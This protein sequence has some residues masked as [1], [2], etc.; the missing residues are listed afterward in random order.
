MA[1]ILTSSL[2][3]TKRDIEDF[4][5]TPAFLGED[6][7]RLMRV[8]TDVKG[9]FA[10]QKLTQPTNITKANSTGFTGQGSITQTEK[11]LTVVPLKAEF[12]QNGEAF[13]QTIESM[14]LAQGYNLDDV[15]QMGDNFWREIILPVIAKAI[16]V[17]KNRMIWFGDT[18]AEVLSGT[19]PNSNPTGVANTNLTPYDGL[20]TKII[21]D[22]DSGDIASDQKKAYASS[23]AGV[24]QSGKYTTNIS[25]GTL[26]LVINGTTYSE[27]YASSADNTVDNWIASHAATINARAGI[28]GVTVA[29][30]T[31]AAIT[32]T[33]T[34]KGQ[35]YTI[36]ISGGDG[37]WTAS[38]AV[39]A[40]KATG[41]ADDKADSIFQSLIDDATEE[42]LSFRDDWVFMVTRTVYRNY[43]D[44]LK[45]TTGVEGAFEI[46]QNGKKVLTY[47][48]I[49]IIQVYEWDKEIAEENYIFPH[50]VIL[51]VPQN[52]IFATDGASD[53]GA[54]DTWYNKDEEMRRY[55]CKY[56][57]AVDYIHD[58]LLMV[59]YGD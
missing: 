34:R 48:G 38:S 30:S 18:T 35:G 42:M 2:T 6:L 1:N 46:L 56:R 16:Q 27:S 10:I 15:E 54:I 24:A 49:P 40:V 45:T 57:A 55:R 26:T 47:E 51:S 4:F 52:F 17:D 8:F 29:K 13:I 20:W 36:D 44:T 37:T 9:T 53:D 59:A 11:S 22:V 33:G 25:S 28:N 43:M 12:E 23:T 21:D 5:V 32:V 3:Y 7:T 41:Q 19:A 58:E 39:A 14:L 50:R 31:S